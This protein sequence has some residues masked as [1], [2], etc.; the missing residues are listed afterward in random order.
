MKTVIRSLTATL[1][2]SLHV[3]G[4]TRRRRMASAFRSSALI[5]V[6]EA[7]LLLAADLGDAPDTSS[8]TGVENYQTL[9]ANNGPR[10]TIDQTQTTLFL[11]AGVDGDNGAQQSSGAQ[12]DDLFAAG[13]RDD[14]DGV[15]NPLDL[16][17]AAGT[18]AVVTIQAT[19]TTD[20]AATLYGWIDLNRNGLFE[21]ATERTQV[22]VPAGTDDQRFTLTFPLA[23]A[24]S[25]GKTYARFRIS[26]D[27]AS[28]NS[29]GLASDGE[30]EDYRFTINNRVAFPLS[31]V[32][33]LTLG[34]EISQPASNW[35]LT[36]LGFDVA[37]IGD[38]DQN[39]TQ[40]YVVTDP[41]DGGVMQQ[42]G[43]KG[44]AYVVFQNANGT[45]LKS[46][47]IASNHNGGPALNSDDVFGASVTSLGDIDGDGIT[48]IAI[49]APGD[50]TGGTERGAVYIVRL[51]SDGTAKSNTKI[52]NSL[53]GGPTLQNGDGFGMSIA[54]PGD[55][56]G[57]GVVDL[58]VAASDAD[59]GGEDRGVVYTMFLKAD[60]TVRNFAKIE[61]TT[62][63]NSTIEE[64][65]NFGSRITSIG[66]VNG[67]GVGDLAALSASYVNFDGVVESI[68]KQIDI[69][70]MNADGTMKQFVGIGDGLNGGP[71]L[72]DNDAIWDLTSAGDV[73]ADGVEDLA[74]II[75]DATGEG[76]S[77]LQVIALTPQGRAKSVQ[78][79]SMSDSAYLSS[80]TNL[81]DTNNDGKTELAWGMP[82]NGGFNAP[83]G[84]LEILTLE[85][86]T[87]RSARPAVPSFDRTI[88]R[89]RNPR[90]QISWSDVA[91]ESNYEVWIRNEDTGVVLVS[92]AIVAVNSYTPTM[93]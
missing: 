4:S 8:A 19:N 82:L 57:D 3:S 90:P 23:T 38:L 91:T 48:D 86:A 37:P 74:L 30:V 7:R 89:T 47:R 76:S 44:A 78:Q 42:S 54:S 31:T 61:N 87:I 88:T 11:G 69:L 27:V 73:D 39:G 52:A 50:G 92:S 18:N 51:K 14:E 6:L 64:E 81:G 41:M 46:V 24:G 2:S 28:A 84:I 75:G 45:V 63:W 60:G 77:R 20:R 56:D 5:D 35:P 12:A 34:G 79:L 29:L 71:N 16:Q 66:D 72:V 33:T 93:D 67:D 43:P 13:G 58:V 70:L 17:A 40:D 53:N 10:H 1:R 85:N 59:V 49:G 32:S 55:M 26:T 25:I 9:T 15:L 80:L 21:N 62:A 68:P 65:E 83:R 36:F 22:A